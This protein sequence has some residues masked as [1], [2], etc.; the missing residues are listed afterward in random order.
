MNSEKK[1]IEITG[2]LLFPITVGDSAFIHET[3][4]MRQTST[5]L[6][7]EEISQTE[8]RFETRNTNYHLHL[9][10]Q[11]AAVSHIWQKGN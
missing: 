8:V 6:S 5:V 4:G 9:I 1:S 2:R 10:S 11:E 3:N 7:L